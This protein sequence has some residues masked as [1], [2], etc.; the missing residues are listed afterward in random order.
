[1]QGS[2][3]LR[4]EFRDEYLKQEIFYSLKEWPAAF[5]IR[6]NTYS[7]VRPHS[8]LG[9][10]APAL[11]TT[12]AISLPATY[13]RYHAVASQLARSKLPAK[14]NYGRREQ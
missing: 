3:C 6:Q 11:F 12:F 9:Y 13:G 5:G 14:P 4:T 8:S 2:R 7:R 1:M 10:Q